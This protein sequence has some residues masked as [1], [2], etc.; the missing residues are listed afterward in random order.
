MKLS[1]IPEEPE[2]QYSGE[3]GVDIDVECNSEN[4][5]LAL[6]TEEVQVNS[7]KSLS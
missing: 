6:E 3:D 2:E 4:S 1:K 5:G 7:K